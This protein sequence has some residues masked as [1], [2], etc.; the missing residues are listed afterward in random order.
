[1]IEDAEQNLTHVSAG[2]WIDC[3]KSEKQVETGVR[4]NSTIVHGD[5]SRRRSPISPEVP[6]LGVL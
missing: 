5:P 1:V 2:C 6:D 3:G 4:G